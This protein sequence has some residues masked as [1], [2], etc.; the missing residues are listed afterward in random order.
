MLAEARLK[1][2]HDLAGTLSN[3]ELIWSQGYLAGMLA[4]KGVAASSERGPSA[5]ASTPKKLSIVYGTET[6]NSKNLATK[7]AQKA[8][9]AGVVSKIIALDQY[10]LTD[11]AKEENLLVV[12]ST[13]GEGEPPASA[14]KFYDYVHDDTV[15][16]SN[17]NFAVIAM[18]IRLILCFAKPVRT[19]TIA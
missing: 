6:G 8:K 1:Q 9:L 4:A 2:L 16:L 18:A 11:L 14:K 5:M 17:T 3:E 12:I 19:W 13:H 15:K 10:R 7:F